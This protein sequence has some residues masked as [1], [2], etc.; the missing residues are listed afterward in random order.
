MPD[1]N[2]YKIAF[3]GN[4]AWSMFNFRLGIIK[5]LKQQGHDVVVI[6]PKDTFTAKIVSEGVSFMHIPI[7]S[8]GTNVIEEAKTLAKFIRIY[9]KEKFDLIFHYTI[10][11]NIYGTIAAAIARTPSIIITTGLGRLLSFKN[12]IA[13]VFTLNLYRV[14][15]RLAKE[16]WFLNN[17]DKSVF[18]FKKIA[19]ENKMRLIKGEGINTD[20]YKPNGYVKKENDIKFLFAGRVIWD[21]GVGQFV[22]AA[23]KIKEKYK[24]VEF[25]ILGFIDPNNPNAISYSQI[26]KWQNEGVIRYLGEATDVRPYLERCDCLIFPSFYREGMSRIL[27]EA[28]AMERPIITTDNVGCREVVDDGINGFLV[29]KNNVQD[30]ILKISDF[31]QMGNEQ[32]K[33]MGKAG[34]IKINKS[35]R[36][37]QIFPVYLNTIEKYAKE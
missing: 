5:E 9:R 17:D 37:K 25:Q 7:S 12:S 26:V 13:G 1:N 34:R 27:M 28:A 21:K 14:A 8:Y 2:K 31:I 35:F 6:A 29:E 15:G 33:E 11:P 22:E 16:V 36:E 24:N 10:K 18:L 4:T 30:L 32:K 3:V 20:W 23:K 19:T